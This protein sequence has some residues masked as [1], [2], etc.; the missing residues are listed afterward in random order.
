MRQDAL[1]IP[2]VGYAIAVE[3]GIRACTAAR[4]YCVP[5]A[6]CC[7]GNASFAVPPLL[8]LQ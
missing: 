2:F 3:A 5:S 8:V 6:V 1:G 4:G 7:L